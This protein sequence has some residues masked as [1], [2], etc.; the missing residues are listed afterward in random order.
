MYV[1]HI[2]IK[3]NEYLRQAHR[4]SKD[5]DQ[6]TPAASVS[7][8]FFLL[9]CLNHSMI[10]FASEFVSQASLPLT[11]A[12]FSSLEPSS[13]FGTVAL[14]VPYYSLRLDAT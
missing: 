2:I 11:F 5:P 9:F 12:P 8:C 6:I 13:C 1:I 7:G 3:S 10:L 14:L 4:L